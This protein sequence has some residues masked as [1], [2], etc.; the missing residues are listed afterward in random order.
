MLIIF[1]LRVKFSPV[2]ISV[3][4]LGL[5]SLF[6]VLRCECHF[7]F[8]VFSCGPLGFDNLVVVRHV[9]RLLGGSHGS[10]PFEFVNDG[11]LL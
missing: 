6:R 2:E 8:A 9:G 10:S 3:L 5:S 1:A 11:D 7:G 4:F